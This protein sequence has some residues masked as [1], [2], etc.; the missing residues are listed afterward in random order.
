MTSISIRLITTPLTVL[1]HAC[2]VARVK[3]NMMTV[4]FL[5]KDDI[6]LQSDREVTNLQIINQY[7]DV[8]LLLQEKRYGPE[9]IAIAECFFAS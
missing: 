1:Q 4:N 8:Q 3:K 2:S 6:L 5:E 9:S 7:S